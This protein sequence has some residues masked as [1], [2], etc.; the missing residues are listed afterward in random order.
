MSKEIP[1]NLLSKI[2]E[3][4]SL[5]VEQVSDIKNSPFEF[6]RET[7]KNLDFREIN[8]KE[9]LQELKTNFNIPKIGKL[10]AN[11]YNLKRIKNARQSKRQIE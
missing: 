8:T 7:I 3:A 1:K 2:A 10:H 4:N 11:Y 5:T 9:E 6:I